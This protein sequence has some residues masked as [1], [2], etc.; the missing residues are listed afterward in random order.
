MIKNK[1]SYKGTPELEEFQRNLGE[2]LRFSMH[3]RE[4]I[5]RY[6]EFGLELMKAL[7][8][9][10]LKVPLFAAVDI[11]CMFF[12]S[13][14]NY[15]PNL[16]QI[17]V[18]NKEFRKNYINE[19]KQYI[20][21]IQSRPVFREFANRRN[22]ER[23][24][25]G[26]ADN[27]LENR[28]FYE[29]HAT[30]LRDNLARSCPYLS[31]LS[32]KEHL[33]LQPVEW[34][35]IQVPDKRPFNEDTENRILELMGITELNFAEIGEGK[36]ADEGNDKREDI[37]ETT[38]LNEYEN[39]KKEYGSNGSGHDASK[40]RQEEMIRKE[41]NRQK[42]LR[43]S[44][45]RTQY[46]YDYKLVDLYID[47]CD[48]F[49]P[50][51]M[52]RSKI[53]KLEYLSHQAVDRT[54]FNDEYTEP[55]SSGA[56][57]PIYLVQGFNRFILKYLEGHP[58]FYGNN[59]PRREQDHI[60]IRFFLLEEMRSLSEKVRDAGFDRFSHHTVH[61]LIS[62][63]ISHDIVK[64][65]GKVSAM[66][67][68]MDFIISCKTKENDPVRS[69][70][71]SMNR[72]RSQ[73]KGVELSRLKEIQRE[74]FLEI[75]SV[76]TGIFNY[77]RADYEEYFSHLDSSTKPIPA[78]NNI[79]SLFFGRGGMYLE[80]NHQLYRDDVKERRS[81]IEEGIE[82]NLSEEIAG[83]LKENSYKVSPS[84]LNSYVLETNG[85]YLLTSLDSS[86]RTRFKSVGT[87]NELKQ[88]IESIREYFLNILVD[89]AVTL[90]QGYHERT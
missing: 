32:G 48:D 40:E 50:S 19:Y 87:P 27:S 53:A 75:P 10:G 44:L 1:F 14:Q 83:I 34:E 30:N 67:I 88:F 52:V 68:I 23:K 60:G 72:L 29:L 81:V 69:V 2:S 77:D 35:E 42:K 66:E 46:L 18:L 76:R 21:S 70:R 13:A 74:F 39:S 15:Y 26:A 84:Q 36:T 9:I 59:P 43:R 45:S 58:V 57:N 25:S 28:A 78:C 17:K 3:S 24:F 90:K 65:L 16:Q 63:L 6:G 71:L 73:Y 37:F 4:L 7:A 86:K 55:K 11:I 64:F 38:I 49:D 56:I 85:N 33:L 79:Y 61:K 20:E 8:D 47:L 80:E 22:F 41:M 5:M 54:P 31:R 12:S 82:Y 62:L 89:E 51:D